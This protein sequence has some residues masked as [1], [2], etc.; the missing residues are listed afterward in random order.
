MRA[1]ECRGER[2]RDRGEEVVEAVG[3]RGRVRDEGP[4]GGPGFSK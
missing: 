1:V 2:G 4:H 3:Y